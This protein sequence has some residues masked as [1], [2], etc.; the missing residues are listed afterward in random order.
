MRKVKKTK[1]AKVLTLENMSCWY[2]M[3]WDS[4]RCGV[5]FSI[6]RDAM[7]WLQERLQKSRLTEILAEECDLDGE[8][9]VRFNGDMSQ[10]TCGF[11]DAL[12]NIGIHGEF[13]EFLA[14]YPCV[15]KDT[16]A[17][18]TECG[19]TLKTEHGFDCFS[20][21]K[22]GRTHVHDWHEGYRVGASIALVIHALQYPDIETT[23][24]DYQLAQV[25]LGI[26][27]DRHG[28]ASDVSPV[29]CTFL[30]VP[31]KKHAAMVSTA[32]K[33][34]QQAHERIFGKEQYSRD[35]RASLHN[36]Q[37]LF[38]CPGS[39]CGFYTTDS[40]CC[41]LDGHGCQ[42]SDHNV[43][44]PGQSLTLLAGF[45]SFLGSVDAHLSGAA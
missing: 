9:F 20:C 13:C 29:L 19:G 5:I 36:G 40:R 35:C 22:T 14:S 3:R 31:H 6:H 41:Y 21:D 7:P 45:A 38:D 11:G 10:P 37:L 8:L 26:G 12:Q 18:C 1:E 24:G 17:V 16:S 34:M 33:A 44:Q 42:M 39:A 28:I 27:R 25:C 32:Q 2:K 4:E 23:S 30:N 43:D 15:R